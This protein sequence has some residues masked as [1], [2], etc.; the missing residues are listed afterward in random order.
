MQRKGRPNPHNR[1][2]S[3]HR[4]QPPRPGKGPPR[5]RFGPRNN[6]PRSR[7]CPVCGMEVADLGQHIR[8]KHDDPESHPRE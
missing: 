8:Q 3:H 2:Q 7:H 6:Q 5:G 4:N 1:S